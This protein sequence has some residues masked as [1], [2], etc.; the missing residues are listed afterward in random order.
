MP[1]TSSHGPLGLP[2]RYPLRY[3]PELLFALPRETGRAALGLGPSLPFAGADVWNAYELSWLG[4]RGKPAVAMASFVVPADSPRL[5]ESKSLK[6]YLNSFNQAR[7]ETPQ[8]VREALRADLSRAAGAPVAVDLV[9]P[10]RFGE[11]RLADLQ[12]ECLDDLDVDVDTYRPAPELLQCAAGA[13][14][15]ETLMSR[16]LKSNCPVTGQPDWA[17]VQVRYTGAPI[18]RAALLR[19][20]VS[21]RSHAGFHEHCVERLYVDIMAACRPSELAVCARYTRRG[22]LDINPWRA[23]PGTA[24]PPNISTPRQ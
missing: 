16:L 14:V 10:G 11:R 13:E 17:C 19:Y 2:T 22:G 23:T 18:D 4:P 15:S 21:F 6:L 3:D 1:M 8:A 12:G 7:W 24:A 5:I 9:L 20:L